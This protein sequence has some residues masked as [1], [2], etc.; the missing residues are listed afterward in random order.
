MPTPEIQAFR[1]SPVSPIGGFCLSEQSASEHACRS[2]VAPCVG[3]VGDIARANLSR[4][5][6]IPAQ[7]VAVS[8]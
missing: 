1:L 4:S 3:R 5:H 7:H 8:F 2:H 6:S